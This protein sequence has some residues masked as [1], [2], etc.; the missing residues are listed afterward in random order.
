[1]GH[2]AAFG[3]D[4]VNRVLDDVEAR[5]FLVEPARK[6]ALELALGIAHV[7]LDEGAGQPLHLPRRRRLAGTQAH[8]HVADPHR[9]P[10]LQPELARQ[11]V[12]LVE[13]TEHGDA[14]RHRRRAWRHRGDGLGNVDR[15]DRLVVGR[16]IVFGRAGG[17]A[18]AKREQG[19]DQ[20]GLGAGDHP[21]SGVQAW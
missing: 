10:R 20:A 17:I 7:E 16:G 9:L 12:T 4:V 11:A 19:R 5:R 14:L 3:P 15:L 21:Q 6:D 2:L 13:Q 8:D 18:R 1:M